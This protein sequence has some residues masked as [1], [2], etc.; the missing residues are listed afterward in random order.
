MMRVVWL[1]DAVQDLRVVGHYI[2]R[3]NP[4]AAYRVMVAIKTATDLL[5]RHPKAGRQGR[6]AGTRELVVA[7]LPYVVPY[8]VS[9]TE[10]RILAVLHASRKWPDQFE[11]M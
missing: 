6:V 10:V 3:D 4:A 2:A 1:D 11:S 8:T 5:E 9:R 7:G